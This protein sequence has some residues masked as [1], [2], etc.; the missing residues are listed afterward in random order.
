MRKSLVAEIVSSEIAEM[1]LSFV[2]KAINTDLTEKDQS[3]NMTSLGNTSLTLAQN[4]NHLQTG[5]SCV[6]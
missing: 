5:I 3:D 1:E 4:L 2:C 6:G